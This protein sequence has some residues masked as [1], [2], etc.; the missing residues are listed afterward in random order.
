[1]CV[2][3]FYAG[4][5]VDS[6]HCV[7]VCV[8]LCGHYCPPVIHQML[9]PNNCSRTLS[10]LT[11]LVYYRHSISES[12]KKHTYTSVYQG[13]RAVNSSVAMSDLSSASKQ[14]SLINNRPLVITNRHSYNQELC[15]KPCVCLASSSCLCHSH[16]H[17]NH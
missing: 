15:S 14:P 16:I 12:T 13:L 10:M 17:R 8:C 6:A 2:C 3:F 11:R 7:C 5:D 1:M 4:E 9:K